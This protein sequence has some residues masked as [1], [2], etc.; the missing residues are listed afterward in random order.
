MPAIGGRV[1]SSAAFI[2][3]ALVSAA[4][5][6]GCAGP[7][8]PIVDPTSPL[9]PAITDS[10]TPAVSPSPIG[11][12]SD[13]TAAPEGWLPLDQA[14]D[15]VGTWSPD[16]AHVLVGLSA[17]GGPPEAHGVRLVTRDGQHV[18]AFERVTDPVWIDDER[19]VAYRPDWRQDESGS[20]FAETGDNG[21]RLGTALMG[22]LSSGQLDEAD[23]PTD[24][25]LSNGHGALAIAGLD[26]SGAAEFAVWADDELADWR[27]GQPIA[28]SPT[29]DR[30]ALIHSRDEGPTAE[31]WLE[32]VDWPGLSTA[33]SSDPAVRVAEA[34]FD[35][36]G[37]FIAYADFLERPRQP[38]QPPEFDLI[39]RIIDLV[40]GV[41]AA[42][43]A[44]ENGDFAWDAAGH[45]VVVGFESLQA[46]W[47]DRQGVVVATAAV[48]GPN[49][50]ASADGSTLLF[51]DAELDE[52]PMQVMRGGV[53]RLLDSPGTLAGPAPLVAPDGSGLLVVVRPPSSA[54]QG[55]PATV[56]LHRL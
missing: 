46:S 49:V 43:M 21:E 39:V 28:W 26:D 6:A 4:A 23:L 8:P 10:G 19:F 1:G 38:R 54:P 33:W 31:G 40:A 56:L 5:L 17:P 30:L 37:Q 55:P 41:S 52:P 14:P 18:S 22:T 3:A 48:I 42:F 13:P 11:R 15:A 20:W 51:Y 44:V 24:P 29:G 16:A 47:Y 27:P 25:A 7:V 32:V 53:L 36:S 12:P 34:F 2:W 35:P 50:V 45:I 9:T